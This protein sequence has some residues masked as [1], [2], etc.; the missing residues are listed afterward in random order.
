MFFLL[1]RLCQ[2]AMCLWWVT[3]VT[4]VLTHTTGNARD[5]DDTFFRGCK[6]GGSDGGGVTG[7]TCKCISRLGCPG[8]PLSNSFKL[9]YI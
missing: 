6:M 7:Q 2:K 4:T 9:F 5:F 1:Y 8:T 3:T